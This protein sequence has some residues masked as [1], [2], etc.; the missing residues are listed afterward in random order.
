[1]EDPS[2]SQD[3]DRFAQLQPGHGGRF[4][5]PQDYYSQD[6]DWRVQQPSACEG[7]FLDSQD[8]DLQRSG[9]SDTELSDLD[10][11]IN[12]SLRITPSVASTSHYSTLATEPDIKSPA[13]VDTWQNE[14]MTN[15]LMAW[16]AHDQGPGTV[17]PKDLF[18]A[19]V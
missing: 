10:S 19:S 1:M 8:S 18:R 17:S 6:V 2:H 7:E 5:N 11:F 3:V 14:G 15:C 12:Y 4:P 16:T 9:L 13:L